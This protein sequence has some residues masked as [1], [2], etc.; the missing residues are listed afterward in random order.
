M[1]YNL[2]RVLP[3][4]R[5]VYDATATYRNLD[6]VYF[7]GSS[8]VATGETVGN[9][10]TDT[11]HWVPVALAGTL[12]PEQVEAIQQ[13]VIAYVQAQGY[14][15]DSNYVH[16]DNNFTNADKSKLDSIDMSTKQD[17]LVSGQNIATINHRSLLE[18]G[19]I[20][21]DPGSGGTS[22]YTQLSNLPS[23]NGTTLTGNVS[24]A[25]PEQLAAKQDT[26]VS[27][28]NIA[29]INGNNLLNGGNITIEGDGTP[30]QWNRTQ[31]D[32]ASVDKIA[33]Y[34]SI[35][36]Q[37]ITASSSEGIYTYL[38]PVQEGDHYI[39]YI[40]PDGT[41]TNRTNYCII[42]F[43]QN[44]PALGSTLELRSVFSAY[45]YAS[46]GAPQKGT[47]EVVAPY[48][49]WLAFYYNA[50]YN[51]ST[52]Y[53][54]DTDEYSTQEY[55]TYIEED[56]EEKMVNVLS[57]ASDSSA[58]L[59][60]RYRL[61]PNVDY[62]L[63]YRHYEGQTTNSWTFYNDNGTVI[64]DSGDG[65]VSGTQEYRMVDVEVPEGA[66]QL[67]L[68]IIV[69]SATTPNSGGGRYYASGS[70]GVGMGALM[71]PLLDDGTM[72]KNEIVY[73]VSK[74]KKPVLPYNYTTENTTFPQQELWSA[75]AVR[76]PSG[77]QLKGKQTPLASFFHGSSGYVTSERMSYPTYGITLHKEIND[78]GIAV[79]DINGFG[80]SFQSDEY[81]KHW[82]CP[83]AVETVKAAY[84]VLTE[85]FN[86]R[87][88]M[89]LSGISMGGAI[90]KSYAMT[91]PQDCVACAMEAPS[92]IGGTFRRDGGVA[93]AVSTAWDGN[94]IDTIKG[95]TPL[96]LPMIYQSIT[97]DG[98]TYNVLRAAD[99]ITLNYMFETTGSG[100]STTV[101]NKMYAPF[102][103]ETVIWH[104]DADVNVPLSY[105][106][107]FVDCTRNAGSNVKLRFCPNC[108]HD[109]N[110]FDWVR[111]EVL[112]YIESKLS[113]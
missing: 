36:N 25:T 46:N 103:V 28:Q 33:G 81:S 7:N 34:L 99:S 94:T 35:N 90:I 113:K 22:D 82:G 43:S 91:Y 41:T 87:K 19:N 93:E 80:I 23:I 6:V 17:T 42:E 111:N 20:Q 101:K 110:L 68:K 55:D 84:N 51:V 86:C 56:I 11:E 95:Y 89:V 65:G 98:N 67:E 76:F 109:L 70:I 69:K 4:F 92:E 5:G 8:Y 96:A 30:L 39:A 83:A 3:I 102:P 74:I 31:V 88:G 105:S 32:L 47:M 27:G 49:G 61:D 15:I 71:K 54:L 58:T 29:T 16:T 78:R 44:K 60:K 66:T 112:N 108:N 59:T 104:G 40:T 1:N 75:W 64:S 79:F 45:G 62:K 52:L 10:P 53:K 73:C 2:G 63:I 85:R 97:V 37:T 106:L 38:V 72:P 13:E 14:V 26:L 100:A 48:D 77:H 24:L 18:G 9:A 12:S 107:Q 21:I 57:G 50:N